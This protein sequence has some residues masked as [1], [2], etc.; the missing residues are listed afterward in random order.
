MATVTTRQPIT[1]NQQARCPMRSWKVWVVLAA[2]AAS[3][4]GLWRLVHL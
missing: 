2:S 4:T 3:I 1:V